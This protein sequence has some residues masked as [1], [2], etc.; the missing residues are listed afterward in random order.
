MR[1]APEVCSD[2][3]GSPSEEGG[4]VS[5]AWLAELPVHQSHWG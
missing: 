1:P 5:W 4:E 2:K 3:A